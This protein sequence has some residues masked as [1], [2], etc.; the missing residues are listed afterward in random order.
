MSKFQNYYNNDDNV[1]NYPYID[2]II[3]S[4]IP[5][6]YVD[7]NRRKYVDMH[8]FEEAMLHVSTIYE[9]SDKTYERLEY[10]GD[11]IFHMIITEYFYHRYNEENEGFLTRLRIRIERGDSMVELSKN[12]GLNNFVQIYGISLNDHILE[13]IFESFIGAF[14]LNFGM[15]Y[16]RLFIIKLIE[17]HKNLSELIA[18]DDN[19]KD[20]LLRYFHQMKWGHPKYIEEIVID[21]K[22][23][24]RNKFISKVKNPF[25]K[26]IGIGSAST[27]KKSEQ[28][29]SQMALTNLGVIID[30]EIDTDWI[31][32]IEKI[33]TEATQTEIKDKKPMS[34]FN[35]NNK[36]LSKNTIKNLL[37]QYNT[38]LPTIDI[39]LKLFYEAMTHR[40][41]LIR[42]NLPNRDVPK[43][44]SI[45]RLQKKSNERLQFL[46]DAVIHFIIGEYLFNKYADSGEGYLTR[47][48]CKLEN[49]ESLFF[50]AKQS[51]ISSYLL[52][53]QN[54]E[55]LHG[56]ENVN[57]I[58]GGLE[59]FVGALYLNIG[60]GTVK[61]FLLEIMRI[62]LDIN[63]IA[64]NETN[65]KDLILQ[66]YNKNKWGHPVYK[67]LKEEGPDHCKI[68]TMGL[69]LGNKLMGIGKA[70]SK[71][72][73]EQIASKKMYQNYI[74]N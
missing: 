62:E 34:V 12:L 24:Q 63:Q 49:S 13:D 32:K 30:G 51:D 39:D 44:K 65:Y 26:V 37:L 33:E 22:N 67:I 5:E 16:T 6:Y 71:K 19:Y 38:K 54:I 28:L 40:S 58:G 17:K 56:R 50:L 14:Y 42:K 27:K 69:Y 2:Y 41:Y 52:I 70:S 18:Y 68:F 61:Q 46:G 31:N 72:K 15:K 57:I 4:Y 64:E 66:L 8:I 53:S 1:I 55:V 21:P 73:A 35:P 48:R 36:L 9:E 47:L 20:L 74:N 29:A 25:D 11:A 3:K 23:N 10:L 60:L 43:S 7:T 59:A 45:V